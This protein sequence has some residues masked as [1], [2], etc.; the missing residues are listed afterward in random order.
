VER[1]A[2]RGESGHTALAARAV[3][4]SVRGN[5]RHHLQPR[6]AAPQPPRRASCNSARAGSCAVHARIRRRRAG[7]LFSRRN[8][9]SRCGCS[10]WHTF[11]WATGRC[12][13]N[14]N[15]WP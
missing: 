2:L 3:L 13:N 10:C 11:G 8:S 14:A 1:L 5:R 15:W 7:V 12:W 4:P 6:T 9:I